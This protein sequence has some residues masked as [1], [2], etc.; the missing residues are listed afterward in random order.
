MYKNLKNKLTLKSLQLFIP[1]GQNTSKD[2]LYTD[3]TFCLKSY[4]L[5]TNHSFPK[6]KKEIALPFLNKILSLVRTLIQ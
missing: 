5:K 2:V 4:F 3:C 6:I 1:M